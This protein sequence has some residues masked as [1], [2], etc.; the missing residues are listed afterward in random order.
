MP[1]DWM[2]GS[3]FLDLLNWSVALWN[4]IMQTGA[5]ILTQSPEQISPGIWS[6][7]RGIAMSLQGVGYG[8]LT[9]FFLVSLFW[10]TTNLKDFT[11]Q[12]VMGYFLRFCGAKIAIDYCMEIMGAIVNMALEVTGMVDGASGG[13]VLDK[14]PQNIADMANGLSIFDIGAQLPLW[15][16]SLIGCLVTMICGILFLI[17]VYGRFFRV[18]VHIALAPLGLAAFGGEATGSAGRRYVTGF[19]AVCLEAAVILVAIVICR[20]ILAGGGPGLG[21]GA[22]AS[23]VMQLASYIFQNVFCMVL[24]CALT[25]GVNRMT[26]EMFG[27]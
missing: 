24:V 23:A 16:L 18:Y 27:G 21:V 7:I 8:L 3:W 26:K 6:A 5:G 2:T 4:G 12:G 25:F 20:G 17:C 14:V 15:L 1:I 10:Q 22:D 11:L 13:I 19:I 9:L